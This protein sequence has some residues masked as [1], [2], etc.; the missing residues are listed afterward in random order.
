MRSL[1]D[2]QVEAQVLNHDAR[3]GNG[4]MGLVWPRANHQAMEHGSGSLHNS[5]GKPLFPSEVV[6]D[7]MAVRRK[8]NRKPYLN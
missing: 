6:H 2:I 7:E 1:L 8:A 5:R 4:C 3:S